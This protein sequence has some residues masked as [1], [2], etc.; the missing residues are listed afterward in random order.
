[1]T[2]WDLAIDFGTSFTTAATLTRGRAEVLEIDGSKYVPSLVCLDDDGTILT[3]RD[4]VNE[5]AMAP[6]RTERV[7]KRALVASEQVLLGARTVTTVDLVAAV[8]ARVAGE[9]VRRFSGQRPSRVVLTHPARWQAGGTELR[10]L[11]EAAERAGLGEPDLVAEPVAAA[12]HYVRTGSGDQAVPDGGMI[13]VYDFGGGTFDTA[14]LRRRRDGF[15]LAGSPGGDVALGGED[16]DAAFM[17]ILAEHAEALDADTWNTLWEAEGRVAE[18]HRTLLRRDI[19]QAKEA[20]SRLPAVNLWVAGYDDEIRVTRREYEKAVEPLLARSVAE[21]ADTV[22][23]AGATPDALVDVY[24]T[25]STSRTPRISALLADLL[26]HVPGMRDD[27]KAVVVLGALSTIPGSVSATQHVRLPPRARDQGRR[28]PAGPTPPLTPVGFAVPAP[29]AGATETVRRSRS[30]DVTV[31]AGRHHKPADEEPADEP[32]ERTSADR[33]SADREAA[34]REAA[35]GIAREIAAI[36]DAAGV[37]DLVGALSP[38]VRAGDTAEALRRP[39]VV[40]LEGVGT[41][42]GTRHTPFPGLPPE[43]ALQVLREG[44][45]E[46]G[47]L[48]QVLTRLDAVS[49]RL[50]AWRA[51]SPAT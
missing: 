1:M 16:L 43:I 10:R 26:G 39:L 7:P 49:E 12:H 11:T 36:A 22:A 23:R 48:G 18:R 3:G 17:E 4:A 33:A 6:D 40:A 15:E 27:P 30:G 51:R 29:P 25:G 2:G 31:R 34:D 35:T 13:G 45:A 24:L 14:V 5:A 19:T 21:L 44:R 37:S 32:G 46:L 41:A 38:T 42:I 20:L 28:P 9:A 8:L 47:V 50:A